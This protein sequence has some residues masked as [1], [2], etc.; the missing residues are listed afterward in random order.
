MLV[1]A[2]VAA[3]SRRRAGRSLEHEAAAAA[4]ARSVVA[5]RVVDGPGQV[6]GLGLA[7]SSKTGEG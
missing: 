2:A 3:D 1:P 7:E 6:L 5:H 4:G